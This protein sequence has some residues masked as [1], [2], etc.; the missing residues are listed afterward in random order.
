[1]LR[2]PI[3][4]ASK[5]II[6]GEISMKNRIRLIL[7]IL[8]L[9]LMFAGCSK[10]TSK[11]ESVP[12]SGEKSSDSAEK[13]ADKQELNWVISSELP[14]A[15]SVKSYDT[16]S[17]SQIEIFAEGLYKIDGDNKTV[18]VEAEGDPQISEDY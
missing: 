6:R 2:R 14:T 8:V 9:A 13:L 5:H 11:E 17:S 16:L 18:P 15:D 1:M 10:E 3:K 12:E 7:L 4:S